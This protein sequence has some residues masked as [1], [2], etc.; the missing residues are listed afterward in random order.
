M[1]WG[2]LL[3]L[4]YPRICCVCER[5]IEQEPGHLCWDCSAGLPYITDPYCSICGDPVDG[6][7]DETFV[8]YACAKNPPYFA[9]A[10]SAVRYRG[11]V[12]T[13]LRGFKYRSRLWAAHDLARLLRVCVETHYA[14]ETFDAVVPVPLYAM[15]RRERGFNQAQVLAS[16]LA[17]E[18]RKPL[19]DKAFVRVRP[20][21]SQTRLTARERAFNVRGAFKIRRADPICNRKLLLVDDVMTTGATVNECARVLKN[22]GATDV[23]VVTVARG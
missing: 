3:D 16:L 10:R 18:L 11:A 19:A 12:Q 15:R 4:I 9:R 5:N 21:P 13:L 14:N 20:T 22:G 17:R 8:C 1:F 23:F 2:A 7:V 6:R